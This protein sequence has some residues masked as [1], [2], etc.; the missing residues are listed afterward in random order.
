[1]P[2]P[3]FLL[4]TAS[5]VAL[6]GPNGLALD[7]AGQRLVV[8]NTLANN[9]LWADAA[10][11]VP[12]FRSFGAFGTAPGAAGL[13]FP[14][15]VAVE[16][17]GHAIVLDSGNGELDHYELD[18]AGGGYTYDAGFLGGDRRS[19]AGAALAQPADLFLAGGILY[20]LDAGNGRVLR[21]ELATGMVDA[22]LADPSWRGPAGI[23]VDASGAIYVSETQGHR[24]LKYPAAGG[25]GRA[26]GGYGTG[27]GQLRLPRGLALDAAGNLY[28]ADS[29]NQRVQVFDPAGDF[30]TSIGSA[31]VFGAIHGLTL[32]S[33]GTLYVA[34]AG[35][36]AVHVFG[37]A[38]AGPLLRLAA[39]TLDFG[40][41]GLGYGLDR[42]VLVHNDGGA[43]LNVTNVVSTSLPFVAG[44]TQFQVPPAGAHPLIVRFTP[45]TAS[46]QTASLTLSSDSA[47]G[48]SSVVGLRG[49]GIASPPVDAIL[50]LDRSGSMG[51]SAGSQ[52]K[53]EALQRAASL[54]VDLARADVGDRLGVVAFD[55][56]GTTAYPI[57]PVT[58]VPPGSRTTACA[59]IGALAPGGSTSIG[60]GLERARTDLAASMSSGSRTD[61]AASM[62]SG[63]RTV[64]VVVSDGME[65]TPPYVQA[66]GP[67]DP[68]V[69]LARYRGIAI[70]TI[71]LGLGTEIDVGVL[72]NLASQFRGFFSLTE[73]RWLLL[74]KFFVEVFG[75]TL[76]EFV[77][78]DPEFEL[79][80]GDSP[81]QAALDLGMVDRS[82][83]VV[84]YWT[85]P[86]ADLDLALV[87]PQGRR[88][89]RASVAGDSTVRHG[90]AATY[91]FFRF[92]LPMG[93][94]FGR[95]WAGRW[96]IEVGGKPSAGRRVRF[97]LSALVRSNLGISCVV[98][99]ASAA[100]GEPV[101]FEARLTEYGRSIL[102]SAARLVVDRPRFGRG[103]ILATLQTRKPDKPPSPDYSDDTIRDRLAWAVEHDARLSA[104]WE[105]EVGLRQVDGP[106]GPSLRGTLTDAREEGTYRAHFVAEV[107]RDGLVLRRECAHTFATVAYP[108]EERTEV[109]ARAVPADGGGSRFT[110]RVRPVDKLGSPLGSGLRAA[111][112]VG[113]RGARCGA[114]VD[115]GDGMYEFDLLVPGGRSSQEVVVTLALRERRLRWKLGDLLRGLPEPKPERLPRPRPRGRGIH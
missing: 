87:T 94:R 14:L 15:A 78:L 46:V 79:G 72:T 81:L 45:T 39:P 70:Y 28:V 115:R 58:D 101:E 74:P 27:D 82:V 113:A 61:L 35:R 9:V 104:R 110:I 21:I 13:A 26:I 111:I 7:H 10:A 103:A 38:P 40:S 49:F 69:D 4:R 84:L 66:G 57:T 77:T 71:G 16:A 109:G 99:R 6:S 8:A 97:G 92:P 59:A 12:T 108:S 89:D 2:L 90:E 83:T 5:S 42:P 41:V 76:D 86:A 50:V 22:P 88:L 85:D 102:P 37:P 1:M 114:V 96:T 20:V 55:Q 17:A 107:K 23:T 60:A 48:P 62:S 47:G 52:T 98:R 56:V 73:D 65:N 3:T 29:G 18:P 32:D 75:D 53:I 93:A 36:N 63:S 31:P 67:N 30:V 34:D 33:A 25:A 24:V 95:A 80:E 11:P 19:F 51:Q 112:A 64:L 105:A 68:R 43:P 54:F 44:E 106:G 91:A 100:T